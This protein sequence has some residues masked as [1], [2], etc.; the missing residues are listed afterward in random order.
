M[1]VNWTNENDAETGFTGHPRRRL[2]G[3]RVGANCGAHHAFH[4]VLAATDNG[5]RGGHSNDPAIRS[6]HR[7]DPRGDNDSGGGGAADASDGP[8]AI[9]TADA[10]G[11]GDQ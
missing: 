2:G 9:D 11:R 3:R 6:V 10:T 8:V 1:A 7:D 5:T 4:D